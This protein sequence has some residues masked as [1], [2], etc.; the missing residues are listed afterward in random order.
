[1]KTHTLYM[2]KVFT[3]RVCSL[4]FLDWNFLK[5]LIHIL[6]KNMVSL[7]CEFACDISNLNTKE[8]VICILHKKMVSPECVLLCFDMEISEI[9]DSHT[10]HGNNFTPAC[11]PMWFLASQFHQTLEPHIS[12]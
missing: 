10:L 3:S 4:M 12:Q 2:K 11:V 7:Q 5:K 9:A 6:Y 8:T 1:M